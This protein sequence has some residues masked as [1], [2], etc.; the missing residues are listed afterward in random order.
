MVSGRPNALLLRPSAAQAEMFGLLG[1]VIVSQ[2]EH[3]MLL[4]NCTFAG[5]A[6]SGRL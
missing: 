4:L 6:R 1:R 2:V 5:Q 3:Q